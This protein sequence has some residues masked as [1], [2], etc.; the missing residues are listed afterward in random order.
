MYW[1]ETVFGGTGGLLGGTPSQ[2]QRL[3][4]QQQD[5]WTTATATNDVQLHDYMGGTTADNVTVK[6]EPTKVVAAAPKVDLPESPL[7]WLDRRIEEVRVA[8]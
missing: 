1:L 3:A 6:S 8:L 5:L 4:Q 7:A 2:Q